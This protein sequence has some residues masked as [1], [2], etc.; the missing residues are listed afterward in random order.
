M[1]KIAFQGIILSVIFAGLG[2]SEGIGSKTLN[3][4]PVAGQ[5][6]IPIFLKADSTWVDSIISGMTLEEKIGQ[7]IMIPAYSNRDATHTDEIL[8]IIEKYGPG[9]IIFFQGGP[10]RQ[11]A[12]VNEFQEKSKIPLVI[13][14]DA[15]W[16]LAMRLDSTLRYPRQ[17]MLGALQED[18]L[19]YQM[20]YDI[21]RQMRRLGVHVN[22]APVVDINNNP[23]NPVINFRSF[24]ELRERVAIKSQMYLKGLE[25]A[26]VMGVLKHFPGHGDTNTDSHYTL[27]LIS[28]DRDRLDSMELYPFQFLI[29]NGAGGIMSA[30]LNVSSLDSTPGLPSSM[31]PLIINKLLRVEMDF[32]GLVFTDALNMKGASEYGRPGD[33]EA[34]AILAGNDIL[35]MPS[36]VPRAINAIRREIKKGN[37]TEESLDE[38]VRKIL[39]L[40]NWLGLQKQGRVK[41][42]NLQ[43]DLNNP[44]YK[45]EMRKLVSASLTLLRNHESLLPISTPES[46]KMAT[47]TIG[48]IEENPFCQTL[49]L[50]QDF[51]HYY[52]RSEDLPAMMDSLNK[53][54]EE[55]QTL[56]INLQGTSQWPGRNYGIYPQTISFL[57]EFSPSA[58][59]ILALFGNPYALNSLGELR[60]TEA[61][62]V[63]YNDDSLTQDLTAQAIF[64]ATAISGRLPVTVNDSYEAGDGQNTP[65][66]NRL[67]YGI[68][69]E[70]GMS[71]EL[72]MKID[73]IVAEALNEKATPG[74]QILIARNSR[75]IY[76]KAFGHHSYNRKKK[77][78]R[79]DLFDLASITK[80]TSTVPALM[81][82]EDRG[83]FNTENTLGEYLNLP[84]TS[85]MNTL[86]IKDILAHQSGLKSWIPFY[87]NTL[88]PLDTSQALF[89]TKLS[90]EYP[91]KL[92]PNAFA[93]RNIVWKD[94]IFRKEYSFDYSISVAED[95]FLR[96]DYRDSVYFWILSSGLDEKEYRY[97]D[98]GYYFFQKLLEE[99]TDTLLY[100]FVYY[101]FYQ[102]LGAT[103]LGYLPLN[104][105]SLS[106]I[107]PTEYDHI[108][109][110]Q[111]I[112]GYVHDPGAAMLGGIGGHAGVFSNANDLAKM[113]QM[114][115]NGG[116]YGGK[117]I[118]SKEVIEKYSSRVFTDNGNRRALGFD[119]PV[120]EKDQTGPTSKK[121]SPSSYGHTGFT[122]TMAWID[123]EYDL[124]YIFLSNRI[125]PDQ[126]NL[127][128]I[129]K[130][131]RTRIQESI[132]DSVIY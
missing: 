109:R 74:C 88:E 5:E 42:Q 78:S 44:Y 90:V 101:N 97:S 52:V 66:L 98:L 128:L 64:G 11:A 16:G 79:G 33:L 54:G 29:K 129:R 32:K 131:V 130:D 91:F 118:L 126:Y 55:Y 10:S 38:K 14:M 105:F 59:T 73:T 87:Y 12:M 102:K 60:Y 80:I 45:V 81:L 65:A 132:Y 48:G 94:D 103:T 127:T 104:R 108:F 35:L 67:S 8:D 50:Y 3:D 58:N 106:R 34:E 61:L 119:K 69:E 70:V 18:E 123:P 40:K 110:K 99:T 27:P 113:M 28:H 36:D 4:F 13:A 46:G 56:I 7:L 57:S 117:Q 116:Y 31:S 30:H 9:G 122:G 20:G 63:A 115:L 47:L 120:T 25:D 95:M 86:V 124:I 100:P 62:L 2:F 76:H 71:S 85:Q 37:I 111:I 82:L 125:H 23:D 43:H 41:T 84:D 72:L 68:P 121:A 1:K 26:G 51:D 96:N 53:L 21:G 114:Y 49:D 22:F 77:L 39:L 89:S 19:I 83:L 75:V 15:E 112:H 17:M 92:G 24:G 93:N 6:S 107:V